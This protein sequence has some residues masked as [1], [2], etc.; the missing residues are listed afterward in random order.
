MNMTDLFKTKEAFDVF[1]ILGF[2]DMLNYT[3][4]IKSKYIMYYIESG[5]KLESF[6]DLISVDEKARFKTFLKSLRK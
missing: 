2:C 4:T 6:I 5:Q 1:L 3:N